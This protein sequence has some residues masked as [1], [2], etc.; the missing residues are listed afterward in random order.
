MP[1]PLVRTCSSQHKKTCRKCGHLTRFGKSATYRT[2]SVSK[3][4]GGGWVLVML[5]SPVHFK[6]RDDLGR[7]GQDVDK[8]DIDTAVT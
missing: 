6:L 2:G 7:L 8:S 1:L 4:W 3:G 5:V